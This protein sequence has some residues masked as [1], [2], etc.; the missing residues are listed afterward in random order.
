MTSGTPDTGDDPKGRLPSGPLRVGVD[1]GGTFTDVILI[2]PGAGE[3]VAVA[4]VPSTPDDPSRAVALGLE[5]M[6]HWEAGM[7]VVHGTTVALNA[8]LTGAVPPTALVTNRGFRDLIE[9]GRQDR[10]DLYALFPVKPAPLVQRHLRFEINQRSWP[11]HGQKTADAEARGASDLALETSARPEP[12]DWRRLRQELAD[13][14]ARSVAICLL[15]SWAD[16]SSEE[17]VRM[18]LEGLDL[19]LTCSAEILPEYREHERFSTAVVNAALVPVM[20]AYL[21]RLRERLSK[22]SRNAEAPG[23]LSI[24]QSCGG[25]LSAGRA[26]IEPVRVLLSGPAGG[27]LGAARAAAEAGLLAGAHPGMLTLDMGG[28]S[29]DVAFHTDAHG[30]GGSPDE[31]RSTGAAHAAGG[32]AQA[33]TNTSVAGHPVAVPSLD[34]HTIGCGGG[35]LVTV[36]SGGILHVGPQSAGADP[37]PVCHGRGQTP[38]VTDAHVLLG[39]I[40]EGPFLD[41]GFRL[42]THGVER[43]FANLGGQLGVPP[44]EAA[45]GVLEVARAAMRRAVGVMSM[46]RGQDPARLPLVAFGGAGG[47]HAAA[48]AQSLAMPGALVPSRAGILSARGMAAATALR[49]HSRGIVA[50]LSAWGPARRAD[51]ERSLAELGQRELEEA[52]HRAADIRSEASLDLRYRGQSFEIALAEGPDR[53]EAFH[54]RHRELYGWRLDEGQVELVNLRVRALV[55]APQLEPCPVE[56]RDLPQDA[57]LGERPAFFAHPDGEAKGSQ[58]R[59]PHPKALPAHLIERGR[60]GPGHHFRGPAIIEGFSGTCLVPPD[61]HAQVTAG[62]HLWLERCSGVDGPKEKVN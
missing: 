30:D 10:P 15:H 24:L 9:I 60:L 3:V 26:A 51:L 14:D 31:C 27:V 54:R 56:P 13:S 4:K 55:P 5:A 25:T 18:Q 44:E 20:G 8:L 34:I 7:E 52:G 2:G 12:E 42:D 57:I 22:L 32:L 61:W 28:T 48:L 40:A 11:A 6:G 58:A 37:G 21:T 36:D 19:P 35:S 17:E 33:V 62:G 45:L 49:D 59:R 43:A 47:L 29:T 41:T 50:P 39:H 46:Q 1:T 23:D 16:P 53:E 38:T